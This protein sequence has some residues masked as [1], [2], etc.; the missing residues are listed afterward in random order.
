MQRRILS[1]ILVLVIIFA[2]MPINA[3]AADGSLSNFTFREGF[4]SYQ[5]ASYS[6]IKSN[7]WYSGYV[8]LTTKLGLMNGVSADEFSPDTN[9]K[10]SETIKLAA[11]MH[12][13]Y[14][15]GSSDF[16]QGTPW[17]Q[18]YVDYAKQNGII[19]SDYS[20][21][22]DYITRGEFA[23]IFANA[24]PDEALLPRNI[25]D[26]DSLPDVPLSDYF[27]PAV[28]KL[29]RAGVL[30]GNDGKG[31]FS[32][33]SLILRREAAAILARM[34]KP[35]LRM[36]VQFLSDNG[37][38]ELLKLSEDSLSMTAGYTTKVRVYNTSEQAGSLRINVD[39]PD[40]ADCRGN[41]SDEG[42]DLVVYARSPGSTIIYLELLDAE[43]EGRVITSAS[44]PVKVSQMMPS[45]AHIKVSSTYDHSVS[46]GTTKVYTLTVVYNKPFILNVDYDTRHFQ[47]D[48][49]EWYDFKSVDLSVQC[50]FGLLKDAMRTEYLTLELI[51]K[52]TNTLVATEKIPINVTN[53][54]YYENSLVPNF[55]FF[56]KIPYYYGHSDSIDAPTY[57]QSYFKVE[58]MVDFAQDWEGVK[59]DLRKLSL[60]LYAYETTMEYAYYS[61]YDDYTTAE[62]YQCRV[63]Y[64]PLEDKYVAMNMT[65]QDGELL[66]SLLITSDTSYLPK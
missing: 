11:C 65:K 32:P 28:Y 13:I 48:H 52:E 54:D 26:D 41:E 20:N 51:D 9:L 59:D 62:G 60:A 36:P 44:I 64:S 42:L 56:M 19:S 4:Y 58:D 3:M 49:G 25:V 6:D 2:A 12:S 14:H 29:Y 16:T 46:I 27:G 24:L 45:D 10:I 47:C 31:T 37:G 1:T 17:Y 38:K 35:S 34:V 61:L 53:T 18:V 57:W 39:D 40:V 7:E 22:D 8:S 23:K 30:T 63:F 15:T 5:P 55:N 33:A 43:T 21:Y 66:F 50:L